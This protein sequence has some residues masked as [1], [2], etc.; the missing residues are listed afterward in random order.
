MRPLTFE[1]YIKTTDFSSPT[2][3]ADLTTTRT[4]EEEDQTEE[5]ED[6][7][8]KEE[9]DQPRPRRKKA[10]KKKKKKKKKDD[11]MSAHGDG[12]DDFGDFDLR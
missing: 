1:K 9:V 12:C 2:T 7:T 11:D 4:G 5:E 8:E 10:T 3:F 6:Q